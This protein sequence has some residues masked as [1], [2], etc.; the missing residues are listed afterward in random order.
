VLPDG[1]ALAKSLLNLRSITNTLGLGAI[2][3]LVIASF[4]GRNK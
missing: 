2:V 3:I 4:F 1:D